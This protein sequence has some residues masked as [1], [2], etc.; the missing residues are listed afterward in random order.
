M[1]TESQS[2]QKGRVLLGISKKKI[3]A[4][5]NTHC[6]GMWFCTCPFGERCQA[7]ECVISREF[8]HSISFICFEI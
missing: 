7:F 5:V 3:V 2:A 8:V 1:P 6:N 4:T